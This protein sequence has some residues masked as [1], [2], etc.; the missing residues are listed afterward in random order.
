MP[1]VNNLP[2]H[3]FS[4]TIMPKLYYKGMIKGLFFVIKLPRF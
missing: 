1:N 3:I 4:I 2:T